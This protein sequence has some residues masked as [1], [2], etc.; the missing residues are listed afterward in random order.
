MER[1]ELFTMYLLL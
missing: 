1:A